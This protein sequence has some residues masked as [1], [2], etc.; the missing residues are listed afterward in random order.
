MMSYPARHW[1][2][3]GEK[4]QCDVC[5]RGC[6]LREGQRGLCFVRG[7]ENNRMVLYTY[8][9][10][11]GYCLDPVEKKPLFH[12]LPGTSILSFGTAGCNLLCQFCQ[13]WDISKSREMDIL[14]DEASPELIAKV[15]KALGSRS[16]AFTY[17]DPVVFLEYAIDVA[18]E[19]HKLG[20][21]T[22][23][24]TAGYI[25][26]EPREEF[27]KHIDAA[28][29]DLKAFSSDFYK[30]IC[31]GHLE[32]VLETLIY[33][34]HYTGTWLEITTLLIPGENDSPHEIKKECEWIINNLGPDVPVHFTAFY[35]NYKMQNKP[36]TAASTLLR[37]RNIAK[38]IGLHYVY[39]G[40]ID[41]EEGESTYCPGCGNKVIGRNWYQITEY[42]L[43]DTGRCKFCHFQIPGY[44]E[45]SA[46]SWGR[47]RVP[48][49]LK[50][51]KL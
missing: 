51:F 15:A 44:F 6:K 40:N 50:N 21:K 12:F 1:H 7:R 27:Y 13:N 17:N 39:V 24:V 49:K 33:I 26:K 30:R 45:E 34:K 42:H 32:T 22:V 43:D 4:I 16:V 35:P 46:G 10:S 9:K 11:S 41:N 18:K 20:I 25:N 14:A 23:A 48:V 38:E 19:C 28:N 3:A 31:G 2:F 37:A 29:V 47:K 36:R 5:P 8:G